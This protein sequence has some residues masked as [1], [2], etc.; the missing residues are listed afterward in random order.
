MVPNSTSFVGRVVNFTIKRLTRLLC[1]V[2]DSLLARAPAQGPLIMVVNHI[3][4]WEA[5]ILYTHLLP[6]PMTGFVKSENWDKAAG[7]FLF[8]LWDGIPIRRGEADLAAIRR[9]LAALEAGRILAIAPEG[10]RTGDG[11]LQR[12]HPGVVMM[13]LRSGAPLLP[14]ACHGAEN[15]RRDLARLRRIPFNIVVGRPFYLNV[16][17]V[18]VTRE[19]RQW[20]T[21]EIMFQI[22]ALLPPAYR[23]VYSDLAVA[24]ERFLRFPVA[25]A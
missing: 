5:P 16:D 3:N 11:Q 23:G 18:K 8:N 24:T 12:G 9:G 10:T 19:V 20:I 14:V 17:G 21:D 6:R 1:R 4:F 25:Q 22:A 13:A 2:D 15:Y 7:R